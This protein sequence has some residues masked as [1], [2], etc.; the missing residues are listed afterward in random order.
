MNEIDLL[1]RNA[2]VTGGAQGIGLAIAKRLSQSGAQ[3]SIWDRDTGLLQDIEKE[4]KHDISI[5]N[6]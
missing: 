4:C 1:G 5:H 3:I 6:V 2:V